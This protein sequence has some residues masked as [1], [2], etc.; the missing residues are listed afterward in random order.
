MSEMKIETSVN[1]Q[2][3][4]GCHIIP[5]S[6][7]N[8]DTIPNGLSLSPNLHRAFDRGIITINED[9][10]TICNICFF[11][12]VCSSFGVQKLYTFIFF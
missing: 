9:Y 3:V 11:Y 8:D 5:F 6:V 2:M 1:I 4:D 7:S 10:D 12:W